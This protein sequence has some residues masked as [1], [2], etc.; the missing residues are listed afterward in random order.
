MMLGTGLFLGMT[1]Q[2]AVSMFDLDLYFTV[3]QLCKSF[4][5]SPCQTEPFKIRSLAGA[6]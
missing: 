3:H 1:T 5:I 2:T 6:T 4:R